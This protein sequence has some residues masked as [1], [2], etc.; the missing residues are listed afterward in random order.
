MIVLHLFVRA[1]YDLIK[2]YKYD[3]EYAILPKIPHDE[4]F[5]GAATLTAVGYGIYHN[6]WI[7]DQGFYKFIL[8][9]GSNTHEQIGNVFRSK[10]DPLSPV[11]FIS[12]TLTS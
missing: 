11:K 9:W 10:K 1:V 12:Y 8:K 4:M 7:F 6:P 2:L 3:E 5:I